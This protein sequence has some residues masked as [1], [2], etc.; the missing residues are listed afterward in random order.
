MVLSRNCALLFRL[1]CGGYFCGGFLGSTR[2]LFTCCGSNFSNSSKLAAGTL[3][4]GFTL[5]LVGFESGF[6][7]CE[8]SSC[9]ITEIRSL[10]PQRPAVGSFYFNDPVA[11]VLARLLQL[12]LQ[13]FG[14]LPAVQELVALL[15]VRLE[16][17]IPERL[18]FGLQ[19]RVSGR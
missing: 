12:L 14:R 7:F 17:S 11:Q 2:T 9:A 4:S 15:V 18:G 10:E 1:F 6:G 16:P 13:P 5:G 19:Q 3:S 8:V